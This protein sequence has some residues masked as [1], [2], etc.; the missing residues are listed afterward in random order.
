VAIT[1]T[2]QGAITE[3]EFVKIAILTS[4]GALVPTRPVAD[5]ERRDFEIHLRHHFRETMAVQIKTARRIRI[6]GRS[7]RLQID[8]GMRPPLVVDPRLWFLLA[9]FNIPAM[10]LDDPLFLVPSNFLLRKS[11]HGSH[12]GVLRFQFQA[13]MELSGDDKWTPYRVLKA[14][15]GGRLMQILEELPRS[16]R[17][18][19]MPSA[20]LAVKNVIWIPSQQAA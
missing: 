5:D 15:L 1:N 9:R 11:R 17:N 8:F 2:Q 10:G 16:S 3:A 18:L 13:S 7:R 6:H 14:D 12:G 4:N 19:T 20:L